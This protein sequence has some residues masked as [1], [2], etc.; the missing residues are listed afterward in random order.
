[1]FEQVVGGIIL[2]S[3]L[4]SYLNK[5]HR[6]VLFADMVFS[7]SLLALLTRKLELAP[8][9]AI[10]IIFVLF[11]ITYFVARKK[12]IKLSR[13]ASKNK[14]IKLG[15][16]VFSGLL[17][18]I[19]IFLVYA[20]PNLPIYWELAQKEKYNILMSIFLLVVFLKRGKE[21]T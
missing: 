1:M 5:A 17:F 7:L 11:H 12:E 9:L 2:I 15:V 21:W 13:V 8:A 19:M 14:V 16:C 20:V 10:F 4:A 6:V 18:G 3:G